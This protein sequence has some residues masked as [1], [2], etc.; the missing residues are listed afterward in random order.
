[1]F[2]PNFSVWFTFSIPHSHHSNN[3]K[4]CTIYLFFSLQR[5]FRLTKYTCHVSRMDI[6]TNMVINSNAVAFYNFVMKYHTWV[7]IFVVKLQSKYT[8]RVIT[9]V[10]TERIFDNRPF[11]YIK[12][13]LKNS[14]I[15]F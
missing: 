14:F 9:Y 8:V 4:K 13:F 3:N 15:S 10:C 7:N 11:M 5:K 1:M 12:K 6:L 2:M